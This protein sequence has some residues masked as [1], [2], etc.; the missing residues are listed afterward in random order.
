MSE[1]SFLASIP[2]SSSFTLLIFRPQ[3]P[4]HRSLSGLE[5]DALLVHWKQRSYNEE[6]FYGPR[7]NRFDP[8]VR[9]LS[10]LTVGLQDMLTKSHP[11]HPM[12]YWVLPT[13]SGV[14]QGCCMR[15]F[16]ILRSGRTSFPFFFLLANQMYKKTSCQVLARSWILALYT[17]ECN[18]S[19]EYLP[20]WVV[21]FDAVVGASSSGEHEG[22]I[23]EE[24][25]TDL[26]EAYL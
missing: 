19:C 3:P 8:K 17:L 16:D 6:L 21:L 4:H 12:N 2:S 9:H 23:D 14:S 10:V 5:Y 22:G 15:C 18:R 26:E 13:S 25:P 7:S 20:I 11:H 1:V 24:S